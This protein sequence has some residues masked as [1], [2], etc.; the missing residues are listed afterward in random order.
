[1]TGSK[2]AAPKR[3]TVVFWVFTGLFS[4]FMLISALSDL[5]EVEQARSIMSHLGFP[6]YM[7]RFMGVAK[8]LG[9]VVLLMLQFRNVKEWAY[10]GFV[11]NLLGGFYAHIYLNDT[12]AEWGRPIILLVLLI[13]SYIFYY[14]RHFSKQ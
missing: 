4:F 12:A 3:T 1:M 7:M 5:F 11:F 9:L 14:H 8:L 6:I 10:A 13:G 2:T